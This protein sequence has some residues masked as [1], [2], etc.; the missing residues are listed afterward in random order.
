MKIVLRGGHSPNCKGAIGYLDEQVCVRNLARKVAD[1]LKEN[2]HTVYLVESNEYDVNTDLRKGVDKANSVNADLFFSIHMNASNGLGHGT[3]AWVYN[4]SGIVYKIGERF[5]SNYAKLG[6]TNRGVKTSHGLYELRRTS[7]PALIFETMF[8]DN[9][10]DKELWNKNTLSDLAL[11]IAN[12]IDSEINTSKSNNSSHNYNQS[13]NN[14]DLVSQHGKCTVIVDKLMIREKPSTSSRAVG[15]YTKGEN[16]NYDYYVDNEGY[17]WISWIG[18]SGK[19]RYMAVRVLST[20]KR[21]GK[22]L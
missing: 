7:C 18:F 13:S 10:K 17:R 6:Y 22:C 19:R 2:G 9:K 4:A 14:S 21:Y 12:A 5:C 1:I 11:G 16:V 20:N 3:E 8:C 15:S